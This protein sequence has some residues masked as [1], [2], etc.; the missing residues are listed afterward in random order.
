M[1][2]V[3]PHGER[4]RGQVRQRDHFAPSRTGA[5]AVLA[6]RP[7]AGPALALFQLLLRPANA[8]LSR[9]RLLRILDPADKLVARQGRDVPPGPSALAFAMSAS[10]RSAGSLCTTPP[11]TLWLLTEECKTAGRLRRSSDSSAART[12]LV[13]YPWQA[14][15][16]ASH[17]KARPRL[18][19]SAR[20]RRPRARVWRR[21]EKGVFRY[22]SQE[23]AN[24]DQERWIRE[25][26]QRRLKMCAASPTSSNES[27]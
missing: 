23:E 26:V 13:P 25:R 18:R 6:A 12:C 24:A 2:R 9:H 15:R 14:A 17:R 10:R 22:R 11:G 3:S 21:R 5:L 16:D 20:S 8:A 7:A 19:G 4:V 27:T 1:P